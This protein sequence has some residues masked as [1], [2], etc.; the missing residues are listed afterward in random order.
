MCL[1]WP[2]RIRSLDSEEPLFRR[3]QV[4]FGP[5]IKTVQF[6]FVP[7]A[8]VGDLVLVH[9]GVAICVLKESGDDFEALMTQVL[10][11]EERSR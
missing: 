2:A 4:A 10:S 3:G 9:A 5:V 1:A 7:E 11:D 6:A 8:K